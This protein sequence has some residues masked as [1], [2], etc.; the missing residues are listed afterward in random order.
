MIN[1]VFEQQYR[2][3]KRG[4][5]NAFFRHLRNQDRKEP[6]DNNLK[7]PKT[8][9]KSS[10]NVSA[11]LELGTNTTENANT[12]SI[13]DFYTSRNIDLNKTEDNLVYSDTPVSG[14][15]ENADIGREIELN[16]VNDTILIGN[17]AR[18]DINNQVEEDNGSDLL[19]V[20]NGSKVEINYKVGIDNSNDTVIIGNGAKVTINSEAGI[21]NGND[22]IIIGNGAK[23]TINAQASEDNSNDTII[24]GNG[25]NVEINGSVR[26]DNLDDVKF[27]DN[28][29][30]INLKDSQNRSYKWEIDVKD[31]NQADSIVEFLKNKTDKSLEFNDLKKLVEDEKMAINSKN[32]NKVS[33]QDSNKINIKKISSHQ[34]KLELQ[35]SLVSLLMNNSMAK[36]FAA[37]LYKSHE[38]KQYDNLKKDFINKAV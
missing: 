30:I 16:N 11:T 31:R 36:S 15:S 29:L 38:N 33:N 22:T 2:D 10:F 1:S 20:G 27:Y 32:K 35:A 4:I 9:N 26:I 12:Y 5:E 6:A 13:K 21:D 25:A 18:V 37:N 19:V 23:V 28:K 7:Q 14:K 3:D 17:G 24:I 34:F 8:A